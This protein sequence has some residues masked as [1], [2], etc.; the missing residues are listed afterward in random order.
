M[1]A[2]CSHGDAAEDESDGR[3]S[4][5]VGARSRAREL[6]GRAR[7]RSGALE[8]GRL[9]VL[10]G[11]LSGRRGAGLRGR[12]GA[13]G[14]YRSNQD[15]GG[16]SRAGRAGQGSTGGAHHSLPMGYILTNEVYQ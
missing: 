4:R 3:E 5:R 12:S 9:L 11:C 1:S 14:G 7:R 13:G 10:L 16:E 8:R 6:G 15:C 2:S